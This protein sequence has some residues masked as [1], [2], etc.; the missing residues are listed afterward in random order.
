[1]T[2]N[3]ISNDEISSDENDVYSQKT[4]TIIDDKCSNDN[5][6]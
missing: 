3:I 2:M 5:Q 6:F 4:H 1:M